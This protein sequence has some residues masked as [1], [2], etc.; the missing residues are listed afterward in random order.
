MP[1]DTAL[2]DALKR[3]AENRL[4]AI[5]AHP[6]MWGDAESVEAQVLLLLETWRR[7]DGRAV[8]PGSF[9][10]EWRRWERARAGAQLGCAPLWCLWEKETG[11]YTD[12]A[13]RLA[14]ALADFAATAMSDLI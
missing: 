1:T 10:D 8:G 9:R 4:A 14:A 13:E 11:D 2:L 6:A 12:L 3:W 7:A 5:F